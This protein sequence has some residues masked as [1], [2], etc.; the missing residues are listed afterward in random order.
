MD[1]QQPGVEHRGRVD[2]Q[3]GLERRRLAAE[4]L[5]PLQRAVGGDGEVQHLEPA[6]Q[7]RLL[8]VGVQP[9]FEQVDVGLLGADAPAHVHRRAEHGD[10]EGPRR[11]SR[12]RSARS[13][14]PWALVVNG[15]PKRVWLTFGLSSNWRKS[16]AEGARDV[17]GVEADPVGRLAQQ[18]EHQL[19]AGALGAVDAAD[20]ALVIAAG[21]GLAVGPVELG[22]AGAVQ[23]RAGPGPVSGQRDQAH[24]ST[25]ERLREAERAGRW[26]GG[27]VRVM[28][29][30]SNGRCRG[31]ELG[32]TRVAGSAPRRA[33]G[34]AGRGRRRWGG[35]RSVRSP[36]RPGRCRRRRRRGRRRP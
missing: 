11:A 9:V 29:V 1:L 6:G 31:P 4:R 16:S 8:G 21:V 2:H 27:S 10:A 33:G 19:A 30:G 24:G 3:V 22:R 35:S 28:A 5:E 25:S 12:R 34:R 26:W 17:R 32:T 13:R 18:P 15:W 7:P 20:Q 14:M 23:R 36:A